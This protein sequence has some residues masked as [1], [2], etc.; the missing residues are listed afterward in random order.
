MMKKIGIKWGLFALFLLAPEFPDLFSEGAFAVDFDTIEFRIEPFQEHNQS[1]TIHANGAC[2]YKN[3]GRP[4]YPHDPKPWPAKTYEHTLGKDRMVRL[5]SFLRKTMWLTHS[6]AVSRAMH[7][8]PTKVTITLLRAGETRRVVC[9][10]HQSD[11]YH[12]L[13]WF[14]RCLSRQENNLYLLQCANDETRR[15]VCRDLADEIDALRGESGRMHPAFDIDYR[16]YV[17]EFR[18]ALAKPEAYRDESG[19][20]L[21]AAIKVLSYVGDEESF[22]KIAQLALDR[23]YYVNRAAVDA[24]AHMGRPEHVPF[25]LEA[26]K[27][28]FTCEHA[29]W[30]LI[31]MGDVAVPVIA[32]VLEANDSQLAYK[33]VRQYINHW[34]E[35]SGPLAERVLHAVRAGM[36]KRGDPYD[37]YYGYVLDLAK[38]RPIEPVPM[39]GRLDYEELVRH[40]SSRFIHG[41]YTVVDGRI[42][43]HGAA[44]RTDASTDHLQ[45][46]VFK[47]EVQGGILRFAAGWVAQRGKHGRK[48]VP[49]QEIFEINVPGGSVIETDHVYYRRKM[50]T[51]SGGNTVRITKDYQVLWQG[52]VAQNGKTF[53]TLVYVGRL[54]EAADKEQRFVL[55]RQPLTYKRAPEFRRWPSRAG[56]PRSAETKHS[57]RTPELEAARDE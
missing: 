16:R 47:P 44:P 45:L 29:A 17:R 24:M 7:T 57:L 50:P 23:N 54:A 56:P 38:E 21:I 49:F 2:V 9:E 10:G 12:A 55:P 40:K 31:R 48:P 25:L 43:R 36:P 30:A 3:E 28:K 51:G 26:G 32:G 20:H 1:L 18:R 4:G 35:L 34:D 37:G 15:R 19:C 27:Q 39:L 13:V 11:P 22:G 53:L 46:T 42:D 6:S 8:H 52:R 5:E 33:L 41:W 14:S